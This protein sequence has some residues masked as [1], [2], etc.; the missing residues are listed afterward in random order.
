MPSEYLQSWERF[1]LEEFETGSAARR[2]VAE[3]SVIET[4]IADRS[5]GVSPTDDGQAGD[6]RGGAE[7]GMGRHGSGS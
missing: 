4:E 6:E 3:L 7:D 5:R 1:A 2:D